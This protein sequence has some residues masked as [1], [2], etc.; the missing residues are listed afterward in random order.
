MDS[1]IREAKRAR[2]PGRPGLLKDLNTKAVFE[3]VAA[4]GGASRVALAD[5]LGLSATSVSRITEALIRGGLLRAGAQIA[6]RIGRRQTLLEIEPGAASVIAV[7]VRTNTVRFAL[8][9]LR[10]ERVAHVHV[11]MAAAD[12]HGVVALVASE[13]ARL[14]ATVPPS[15]VTVVVGVPGAWDEVRR[16]VYCV[17]NI[18]FLDGVDLASLLER[19]LGTTVLIDNDVNFAA[20]GEYH[21][22]AGADVEDV[23]YL[24]LG[25]G[26]GSGLVVGGRLHRGH[27]GFAGEIGS[28][29]VLDAG[30][31]TFVTLESLIGRAA[32][33][34]RLQQRG[35]PHGVEALL[36]EP[37]DRHAEVIAFL[38]ERCALAIAA[39]ASLV[40]PG[41]VVL[42]GSIGRHG[43]A[44]IPL[45]ERALARLCDY[46]PPIL[47]TRL[48][49]DAA[50]LG[51]TAVGLAR[52]RADLVERLTADTVR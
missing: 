26:V 39:T 7:D 35:W 44:L 15:R 32:L 14:T 43:A 24:N 46:R 36:R 37:L 50:L 27:A 9:D 18:P 11:P 23:C 10:G 12:V 30:S 34:A 41:L 6:S 48:G 25:S 42:G 51:A 49:E 5:A 20:L 2:V 29:P 28:L 21:F 33:D 16:R 52:T 8:A 1:S 13:V 31:G 17:P 38:A 45:V 47:P 4:V 40:D 22:G 19:S 3:H